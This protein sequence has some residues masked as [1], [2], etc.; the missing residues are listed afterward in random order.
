[1]NTLLDKSVIFSF[2]R[3]GYE[4]H[5]K[6]YE[7]LP[8]SDSLGKVLITGGTSGIGKACTDFLLD[9]GNQCIVT[10]RDPA[11][12]EQKA[13]LDAVS[14]DLSNWDETVKF[15]HSVDLIDHL[16]L[17]AGGMPEQYRENDQ[18]CEYQAASQLL[19]HV[20][21]FESLHRLGK[22]ADRAKVIFV[23]SG[24]MLLKK[25]DVETLF[26]TSRY[27]K[28]SQY[29]NVKRAQVMM[30][31][32]LADKYPQYLFAAMH[33]GWVATPALEQ[34]LPGFFSFFSKRLRN[35]YQGSDTILWLLYAKNIESGK[36]WFDRR[37]A[38]SHP[39]SFTRTTQADRD[40]LVERLETYI[41]AV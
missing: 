20:L 25:L 30:T 3:S 11:K 8:V 34:A 24:G 39:L 2:D 21:L 40:L 26:Q 13:G 28:V 37:L 10:G 22:L 7:E 9:H 19:G 12:F 32:V 17:N 1:M 16:V 29:A 4:R 31:E 18:G 38:N 15:A 35:H 6:I 33:P 41:S 14:L 36:F 23:S 27:D 5:A